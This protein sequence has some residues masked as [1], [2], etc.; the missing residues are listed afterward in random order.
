MQARLIKDCTVEFPDYMHVL[1]Q[2]V[3][4]SFSQE[5]DEN[6][7]VVACGIHPSDN[8]LCFMTADLQVRNISPN[9]KLIP[10]NAFVNLDGLIMMIQFQG[11]HQFHQIDSQLAIQRSSNC[12]SYSNLSI[13]DEELTLSMSSTDEKTSNE[14]I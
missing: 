10:S 8:D 1:P 4:N 12:I 13:Q 2:E 5:K 7:K 14:D 6:F 9:G 11:D 3:I